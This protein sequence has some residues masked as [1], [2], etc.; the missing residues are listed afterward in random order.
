[1]QNKDI[2]ISLRLNEQEKGKLDIL[3]KIGSRILEEDGFFWHSECTN[4]RMIRCLINIVYSM[5]EEQQKELI[6]KH[7]RVR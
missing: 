5:P 2:T 7:Y 1:M 3:L 6:R 4:S